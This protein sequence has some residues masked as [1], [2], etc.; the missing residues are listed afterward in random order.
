MNLLSD[1]GMN[2]HI[3]DGG[4]DENTKTSL[5]NYCTSML[6]THSTEDILYLFIR[7]EAY[8]LHQ[9]FLN[10]FGRQ[11]SINNIKTFNCCLS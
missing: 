10:H 11:N 1:I 5:K 7:I 9:E 8:S 6:P 3:S 4:V 2:G